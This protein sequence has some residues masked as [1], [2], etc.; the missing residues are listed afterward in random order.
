M[1][2]ADIDVGFAATAILTKAL[3]EKKLS[4]LQ[5]YE[6]KK[7]CCTMLAMIATK[8]QERHPLKCNFARKLACLDPRFIVTEQDTTVNMFKQVLT[9]LVDTKWRTTEQADGI[10]TQ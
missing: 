3:K 1:A 8:I 10:L 6:F 7:E 9:K 4:Q 2:T 5:I